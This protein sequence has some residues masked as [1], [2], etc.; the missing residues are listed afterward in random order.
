MDELPQ[1]PL[2]RVA[3]SQLQRAWALMLV[4]SIWPTIDP[5]QGHQIAQWVYGRGS[6]T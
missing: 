6:A 5:T 3:T 4:R 1:I 2:S